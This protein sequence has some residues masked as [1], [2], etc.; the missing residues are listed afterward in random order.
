MVYVKQDG[1]FKIFNVKKNDVTIIV[2]WIIEGLDLRPSDPRYMS[3]E[4]FVRALYFEPTAL[5]EA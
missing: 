4:G 1:W 3:E 2:D 5:G